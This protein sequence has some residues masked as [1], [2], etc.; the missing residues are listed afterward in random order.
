VLE[1]DKK[2]SLWVRT[3][4]GILSLLEVQPEGKKRMSIEEFVRGYRVKPEEKLG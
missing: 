3:G 2:E 1:S 4:R